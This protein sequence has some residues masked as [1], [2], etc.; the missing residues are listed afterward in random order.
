MFMLEN[1]YMLFS[2]L[3]SQHIPVISSASLNHGKVYLHSTLVKYYMQQYSFQWEY[4]I[5]HNKLCIST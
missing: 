2:Y 3:L 4:K 5:N 1:R